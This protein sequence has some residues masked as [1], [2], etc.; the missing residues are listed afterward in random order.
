MKSKTTALVITGAVI[1][2]L[3]GV[4]GSCIAGKP[5]DTASSSTPD[6]NATVEFM[7]KQTLQAMI[8]PTQSPTQT[9]TQEPTQESA[10]AASEEELAYVSKLSANGFTCSDSLSTIST[11]FTEL[12]NNINLLFDAA[13]IA[14]T[15]T[16][17]DNFEIAC[18][19]F[20]SDNPPANLVEVNNKCI[21]A[22]ENFLQSAIHIRAGLNSMDVALI[23]K[24]NTYMSIGTVKI[25][26]AGAMIEAMYPN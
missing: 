20:A 16:L 2:V 19:H 21:E 18:T 26:E 17:V 13:Y 8:V 25:V 22:D 6:I 14:D 9:P 24:A 11:R 12:G 1:L 10:P 7:T 5:S 23:E 4:I 3:C 15:I